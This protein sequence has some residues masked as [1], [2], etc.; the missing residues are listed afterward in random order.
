MHQALHP[1]VEDTLD[2]RVKRRIHTE[3]LFALTL[4]AAFVSAVSEA[5][6]CTIRAEKRAIR[7]RS[8]CVCVIMTL[9][10][11]LW[12]NLS[13]F[14]TREDQAEIGLRHWLVLPMRLRRIL[15]KILFISKAWL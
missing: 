13:V 3:R 5:F 8:C 14:Y 7:T 12:D 15:M 9:F 1:D 11:E 10:D 6:L 4:S 2:H